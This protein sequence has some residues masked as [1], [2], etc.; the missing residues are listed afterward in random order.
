MKLLFFLA[1]FLAVLGL[2]IAEG[3]RRTC[4]DKLIARV[5]EVCESGKRLKLMSDVSQDCCA[6]P[7]TDEQIKENH[8]TPKE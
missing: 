1:L 3:P 6:K 8:C 5:K 4:G 7:C 2:V